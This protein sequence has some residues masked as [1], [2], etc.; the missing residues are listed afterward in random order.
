VGVRDKVTG[1]VTE[2]TVLT[3]GV[4]VGQEDSEY[5]GEEQGVAVGVLLTVPVIEGLFETEKASVGLPEGEVEGDT[6]S[7]A[8]PVAVG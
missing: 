1:P 3:V 4:D 7:V 5:A 6:L 8:R 2:S